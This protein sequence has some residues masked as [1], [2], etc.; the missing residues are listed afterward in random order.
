MKGGIVLEGLEVV[1]ITTGTSRL[2][3]HSHDYAF[4][5]AFISCGSGH[6][7]PIIVIMFS[8][9]IFFSPI[10]FKLLLLNKMYI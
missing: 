10:L 9:S 8:Y 2:C 4:T 1:N 5:C 3:P 6:A 7:V